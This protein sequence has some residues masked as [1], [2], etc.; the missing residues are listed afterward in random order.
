MKETKKEVFKSRWWDHPERS[1]RS[2]G[3][4]RQ[5]TSAIIDI[6]RFDCKITSLTSNYLILMK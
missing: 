3:K 6:S 5:G 4:L 1:D 2:Q